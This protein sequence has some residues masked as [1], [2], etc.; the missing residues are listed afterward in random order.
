[1][2]WWKKAGISRRANGSFSKWEDDDADNDD[3][4]NDD[5]MKEKN[6]KATKLKISKYLLN[7]NKHISE[8]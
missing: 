6:H 7:L 8:P 1:M 2:E 4:N 3:D 5:H